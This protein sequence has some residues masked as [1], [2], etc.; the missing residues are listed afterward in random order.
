MQDCVPVLRQEIEALRA[1]GAD[2]VQ[3][4]EPWLITLI[5]PAFREKEH[6]ADAQYEM[7]LCVDLINQT[8]DGIDGIDTAMHLCHAHYARRHVTEGPYDLIM[9]A[10]AKVRVGTISMEY[11]TPVAGGMASLARFPE[12]P[13]LGLG[14][15]DQTDRHVETPQEVAAR[16]EQAMRHVDKS[17]ITLHPDCGFSP[18]VQNPM[19]LDEAYLKL[20]SMCRAAEMLRARH[21]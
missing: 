2:T 11:A 10:L 21:G 17:R 7:D 14:C 16:V 3:L 13:R 5:D 8:L 12:G 19:D 6:V 15:I 9:P 20:K 1:A 4:D 18:S